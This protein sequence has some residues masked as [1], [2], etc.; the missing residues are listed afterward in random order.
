MPTSEQ[1]GGVKSNDQ[2]KLSFREHPGNTTSRVIEWLLIANQEYRLQS[3]LDGG[4]FS[5]NHK[6]RSFMHQGKAF[7][8]Q[9]FN[10]ML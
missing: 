1:M 4:Q 7:G 9:T 10:T 3:G 6:S 2:K 5:G 8:K